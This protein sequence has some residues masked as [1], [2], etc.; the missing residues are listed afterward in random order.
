MDAAAFFAAI[1]EES[2]KLAGDE[3]LQKKKAYIEEVK[4]QIQAAVKEK[5]RQVLLAKPLVSIEELQEVFNTGFE[6]KA[7]GKK[8]IKISW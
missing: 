5:K 8:K 7:Q 4:S 6:I 2:D 3:E 1:K